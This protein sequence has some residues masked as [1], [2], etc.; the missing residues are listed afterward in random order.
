MGSS[1]LYLE[2]FIFL[3][4]FKKNV[5]NCQILAVY[6]SAFSISSDVI[7]NPCPA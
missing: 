7:L 5:P 3:T 2:Y 4:I 1:L 6:M